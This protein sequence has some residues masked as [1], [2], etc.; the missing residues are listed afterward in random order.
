LSATSTAISVE[1]QPLA[2]AEIVTF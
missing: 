2:D 1:I